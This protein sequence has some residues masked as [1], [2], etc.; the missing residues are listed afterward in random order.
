MNLSL[1]L[2]LSLSQAGVVRGTVLI[3]TPPPAL[4]LDSE[5]F[6]A[7]VTVV[8]VVMPLGIKATPS[9]A[10]NWLYRPQGVEPQWDAGS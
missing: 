10:D 4:P 9:R 2:S 7:V 1:S 5:P 8:S 6:V 3:S